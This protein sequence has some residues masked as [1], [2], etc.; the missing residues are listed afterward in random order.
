MRMGLCNSAAEMCI[1]DF[2]AGLPSGLGSWV[3]EA[4]YSTY[5]SRSPG[6]VVTWKDFYCT[7]LAHVYG[8]HDMGTI[9]GSP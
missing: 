8:V 7:S 3:G 5:V 2:G 6:C 4:N 9:E 1:I